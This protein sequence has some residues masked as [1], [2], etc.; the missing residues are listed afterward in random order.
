MTAKNV[1]EPAP[2]LLNS[3]SQKERGSEK[4]SVFMP[5]RM[6]LLGNEAT[7]FTIFNKT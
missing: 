7:A 6:F 4:V 2:E 5:S 1:G 3:F